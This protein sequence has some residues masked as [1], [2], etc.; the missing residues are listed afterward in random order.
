[1]ERDKI[2][3]KSKSEW[4]SPLVIVTKKDG[5]VRLFVDYK[6]KVNQ[7]TKFDTYPTCMPGVKE[8]LDQNGN[9]QFITTL[10]L[11]KGYWQV[12]MSLEDREK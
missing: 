7:V 8:L 1:M 11:A 9:A 5:R 4:A 3:E 2:I 6:I 12:S 10:N